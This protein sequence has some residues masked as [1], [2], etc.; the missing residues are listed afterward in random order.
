MSDTQMEPIHAIPGQRPSIMPC[1]YFVLQAP[2]SCSGVVWLGNPLC[3]CNFSD[4]RQISFPLS[5]LSA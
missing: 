1:C 4:L 3:L 2:V 5:S